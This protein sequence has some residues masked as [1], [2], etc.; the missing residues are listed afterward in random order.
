M[1]LDDYLRE[2]MS[3]TCDDHDLA[4]DVFTISII[5][6]NKYEKVAIGIWSFLVSIFPMIVLVFLTLL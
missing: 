4:V 2:V 5:A 1:K 3:A 6:M